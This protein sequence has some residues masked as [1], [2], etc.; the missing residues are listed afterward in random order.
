MGEIGGKLGEDWGRIGGKLGADWGQ[1]GGELG[2]KLGE[3]WGRI[4]GK[5]GKAKKVKWKF[6]FPVAS[7]I[8]GT[9]SYKLAT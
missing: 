7:R 4:E 6:T 2:V 8:G 3:N 1:I 9:T 5:L